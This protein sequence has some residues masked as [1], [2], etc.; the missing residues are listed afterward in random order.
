M[1]DIGDEI[2]VETENYDFD[3]DNFVGC[4]SDVLTSETQTIDDLINEDRKSEEE[5]EESDED[6][7]I[8]TFISA[9]TGLRTVRKYLQAFE[10]E[11]KNLNYLSIIEADLFKLHKEKVKQGKITNFFSKM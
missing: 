11:E 8:P 4:D 9:L 6:T 3:F 7:E 10:N 2:D 5:I 1:I